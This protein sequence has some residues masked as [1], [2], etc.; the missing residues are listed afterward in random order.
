[1]TGFLLD[2]NVLLALSLPTHQHHRRATA[3]FEQGRHWA[4]TPVTE[5]AFVR[6]IVKP[7]VVGYEIPVDQALA[8][9]GTM[10]QLPGHLFVPDASSLAEPVIDVAPLVGT[11]QVTDF[12]LLNLA[13]A[14]D[15][16]FATLDGSLARAI[17]AGD[18]PHLHVLSD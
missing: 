17:S 6:L 15:L 1:M 10:R 11:K 7:R 13:A 16:L 4:T 3:W 9:L 14:H 18:R 8:A 12:H 2:V 5:T